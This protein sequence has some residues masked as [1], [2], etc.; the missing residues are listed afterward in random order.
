MRN[1]II[2]QLY[3]KI[4]RSVFSVSTILSPTLNTKL[5]YRS[6]F[7]RPLNLKNPQTFNEKLLWLKLRKYNKDPLVIQCADKFL[8]RD[9]VKKC[10]CEEILIKLIGV[11]DSAK[12]IPWDDLPNKFVLKWNFGA[13]MNIICEEKNCLERTEVVKQMERW[14]RSKCWLSHSEMQYKYIP[15][16]IICEEYLENRNGSVI[17]DYKVYCFHGQPR[18]ILVM[19]N[20]GQGQITTEFFDTEWNSLDNSNK[21]YSP[22]KTTSMPKCLNELIEYAKRLSQPFPFVRCDFYVLDDTIFFGELTFTP[23]GGLYTSQ[24]KINGKDMTEFLHISSDVKS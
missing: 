12:D 6:V 22:E 23:A 20:R 24:T 2:F 14:K 17:P 11:W 19:H 10:G 3:K 5:R 4:R 9:Y 13:G 15:K 16:K 1:S 21:Y 18:A 8:V 7:K